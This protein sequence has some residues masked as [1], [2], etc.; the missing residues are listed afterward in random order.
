MIH[1]WVNKVVHSLGC[2]ISLFYWKSAEMIEVRD[3]CPSPKLLKIDLLLMWKIG[4]LADE[5]CESRA[6]DGFI[7]A[8]CAVIIP[9]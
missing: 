3:Y 7:V 9:P 5:S 4:N 1:E 6:V 2:E 8:S